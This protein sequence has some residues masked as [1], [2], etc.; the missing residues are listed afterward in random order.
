MQ[1]CMIDNKANKYRYDTL[2]VTIHNRNFAGLAACTC[3]ANHSAVLFR[4]RNLS[5]GCWISTWQS[6]RITSE[7]QI[8]HDAAVPRQRERHLPSALDLT[9]A[10]VSQLAHLVS[11]LSA[12]KI[13][14]ICLSQPADSFTASPSLCLIRKKINS[15]I[16]FLHLY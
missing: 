12:C 15:L 14:T 13:P 8:Y 16:Y 6:S 1:H 11:E 2:Q 3:G 9:T 10:V 4:G 7:I 5:E